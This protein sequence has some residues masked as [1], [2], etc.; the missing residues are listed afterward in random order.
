MPVPSFRSMWKHGVPCSVIITEMVRPGANFLRELVVTLEECCKVERIDIAY[1]IP[2]AIPSQH[3]L[4]EGRRHPLAWEATGCQDDR[5]TA[6][7][8]VNASFNSCRH[9]LLRLAEIQG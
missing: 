1:A 3:L 8:F 6:R 7:H 4:E 5:V 9:Y 2:G